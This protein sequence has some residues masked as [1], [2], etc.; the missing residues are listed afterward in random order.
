MHKHS[1]Q[2]IVMWDVLSGDFDAGIS[3][4]QCYQNVIRNT[5]NGS[6][7]VFHDSLKAWDRLEYALPKTIAF[8]K[9]KGFKFEV[10]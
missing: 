6:I 4:E 1:Q 9:D 7:I 3:G 10:L 8:L 2:Q 5:R